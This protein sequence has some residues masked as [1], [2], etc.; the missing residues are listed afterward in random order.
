M[1]LPSSIPQ[2]SDMNASISVI[3]SSNWDM[4]MQLSHL[5]AAGETVTGASSH[6]C[7]GGKGANQAVAAARAGGDVF[8]LSCI[9]E[10]A[11]A[12]QVKQ[13][14]QENQLDTGGLLSISGEETGKAMIFVDAAGENC[15]AVADGANARLTPAILQQHQQQLAMSSTLLLQMEIPTETVLAAARMGKENEQLV[16]LNPAPAARFDREILTW[17]SILTPNRV[18]MEQICG[19]ELGNEQAL[20]EAAQELLGQGPEAIIVTLGKDGAILITSTEQTSFDAYA[21]EARDTTAAGDVFNGALA[22]GLSRNW[23]YAKAINFAVAAAAIS[24]QRPGAI[25][26]IPRRQEIEALL[27]SQ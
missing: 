11:T 19:R 5:P 23:A 18:E 21:V 8:F 2:L 16:I 7:L 26:S 22:A 13:E 4:T 24:V 10:D 14:L 3:G 25:P 20:C 12:A 27:E 1:P 6:S 17:V 9:G 15:I